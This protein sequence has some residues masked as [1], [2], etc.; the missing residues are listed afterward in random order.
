MDQLN[1]KLN[2]FFLVK[3]G[4]TWLLEY[5]VFF[6]IAAAFL[7]LVLLITFI[8][9][10]V[11]H[12][13]NKKKFKEMQAKIDAAQ[14]SEPLQDSGELRAEIRAEME[15]IIREQ[16]EREYAAQHA[17]DNV[18]S[19]SSE[20]DKRK[21]EELNNTIREKNARIDELGAA[22]N[23]ANSA[24][25]NNSTE[26][27]RTINDL[28]QTNKRLQNDVNILK[29]EN[30]HLK[31]TADTTEEEAAPVAKP[32][33]AKPRRQAPAKVREPEPEP[34]D[35]DEE[36][37]YYDDYGDASSDIKV[38]LKYDRIKSNWVILRSDTARTYRRIAT[39]QEGLVVAKDLARR[40]HAQ[41]VV[42][43]KD[44]KFQ[45]I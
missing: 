2:E 10:G 34:E 19:G 24:S 8:V 1:L 5:W 26:L 44:G 4:W 31:S 38:T 39:K 41:L 29:A 37:E 22:L 27:Y 36:D 11:R 28:N 14:N 3:L 25:S 16:V 9:V 30:A 13:K 7:L 15:P 21:I 12:S 32:A 45:K 33:A 23:K 35:D 6:V 42:H 40:L 17:N 43:K 20:E 18:V